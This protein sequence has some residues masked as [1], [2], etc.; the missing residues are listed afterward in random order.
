MEDLTWTA[1]RDAIAS[2]KTSVIVATGGIEQNGPYVVTGKHNYI[3][4]ILTDAIARKLDNALI[5]PII[6]FVPEGNINPP[7][8]HMKFPGTISLQNETFELLLIDIC[9]S[10]K[11]HGFLNII[12]IGDS[13]GNQEGM[14]NVANKL[15][16]TWID[17]STVA[18]FISEHYTTAIEI[19]KLDYLKTIGVN[20]DPNLESSENIHSDY[21]T[22]AILSTIDPELIRSNSR[23]ISDNFN[24]KGID[25]NPIEKTKA[26][27]EKLIEYS[28]N[29]T[30]EAIQKAIKDSE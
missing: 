21:C 29:K 25:L 2:G 6:K 24:I 8:S 30:V 3:L 1:V 9:N 11:Q 20:P 16:D 15:N 17:N 28:V 14:K 7:T 22:E 26:D 10:L 27:G 19:R 12:L 5:A 23:I 13:G 4:Q 18:H